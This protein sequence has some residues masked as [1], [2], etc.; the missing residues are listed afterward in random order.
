MGLSLRRLR[1]TGSW[2]G[3]CLRTEAQLLSRSRIRPL[4]SSHLK[5]P[6]RMYGHT[7]NGCISSDFDVKDPANDAPQ[8]VTRPAH[9]AMFPRDMQPRGRV[10]VYY[11]ESSKRSVTPS[12][13]WAVKSHGQIG[14]VR[15]EPYLLWRP[16]LQITNH[17]N[18]AHPQRLMR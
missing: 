9:R 8:R 10:H 18:F 13:R 6:A 17:C 16:A 1:R 12:L 5:I 11:P 2:Q 15:P 4:W 14:T 7:G 3:F